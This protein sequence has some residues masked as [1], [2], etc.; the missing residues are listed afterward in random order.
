MLFGIYIQNISNQVASQQHYN[1]YDVN[2]ILLWKFLRKKEYISLSSA[3]WLIVHFTPKIRLRFPWATNPFPLLWKL[4]LMYFQ[5]ES[6]KC[7]L[8][9][10]EKNRKKK[11]QKVL[12]HSD[13]DIISN[14]TI[15]N[16]ILFHSMVKNRFLCLRFY[17]ISDL[18]FYKF[19]S[20]VAKWNVYYW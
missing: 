2:G 19:L 12:K 5:I 13:Y 8:C 4:F 10:H 16:L 9:E 15:Y 14:K 17:N 11:Q 18:N 20:N 1:G 6:K 7:S 3:W